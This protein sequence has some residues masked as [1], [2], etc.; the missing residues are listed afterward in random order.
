MKKV[1]VNINKA[2]RDGINT[3]AAMQRAWKLDMNNVQKC[4]HVIGVAS[5]NIMGI[6]RILN[7]VQDA[8][9]HDR[10]AFNL[11]ACTVA[12]ELEIKNQIIQTQ[13]GLKYFVTKY[14]DNN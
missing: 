2:L 8:E 4:S 5:G 7:V 6:Y 13:I 9:L 10:I 1:T 14:I 3:E 12:E 11:A